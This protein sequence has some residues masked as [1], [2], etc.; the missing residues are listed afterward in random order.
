MY[1]FYGSVTSE[2]LRMFVKEKYKW[3]TELFLTFTT[4][5]SAAKLKT[6][7]ANHISQDY[8]EISIEERMIRICY[9]LNV[10]IMGLLE[11]RNCRCVNTCVAKLKIDDNVV[12]E[13]ILIH[14]RG[15][16]EPVIAV[17]TLFVNPRTTR[18]LF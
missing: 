15:G 12:F 17:L 13:T 2:Q 16:I 1:K 5:G 4:Y 7:L 3:D 18:N 11:E 14:Y 9:D 8:P 6:T 10:E